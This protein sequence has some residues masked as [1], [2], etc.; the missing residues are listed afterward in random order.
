MLAARGSCRGSIFTTGPMHDDVPVGA[1]RRDRVEEFE[2]HPLVDHAEE[3]ETRMRDAGLVRGIGAAPRVRWRSA[4]RLRCSGTGEC[5]DGCRVCLRNSVW[6]PVSTTS[7]RPEVAARAPHRG[8][9]TGK[10][11]QLVHA[12]VNHRARC[13]V[14]CECQ[15][16]R[17]VVPQQV[18][19]DALITEEAAE[20]ARLQGRRRLDRQTHREPWHDN[21]N[22]MLPDQE[23]EA[24]RTLGVHR[25]FDI[26]HAV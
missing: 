19:L 1:G 18:V 2:V 5:C 7:A 3:S 21:A 10:C 13:Q 23:I 8:R 14:S 9:R 22:A 4:R 24:G 6:P 20:Q 12:V 25:L 15:G 17:R 11:R 16:H 26:E